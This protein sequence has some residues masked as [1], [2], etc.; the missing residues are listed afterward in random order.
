MSG[1]ALIARSRPGAW[2]GARP[3]C[4]GR[5][6]LAA[7]GTVLAGIVVLLAGCSGTSTGTPHSAAATPHAAASASARVAGV[8]HLVVPPGPVQ[9]GNVDDRAD[10]V[11]PFE[12][13]TGCQV[14]LKNASTDADAV[15]DIN[16]G[17][18]RSY[19]DG[20]L[21]SPE[22]LGQLAAV[23]ALQPL[24]TRRIGGYPV[25]SARLRGS[26]GEQ[27][28]GNVY[29]MPYSW[30]TY[31]TG[32]DSG[33]VKPAPQDWASLFA[34]AS[35]ARHAGKITVPDSP[36]TLALAALYLKSARPSLGI[37]DPFELTKPQLAA[38]AQAVS[39]ARPGVGTFWSQ[40]ATVIGQLGDGQDVL[41]AVL[42]HQIVE[43]SRAGLPAAGVP[44][45]TAAA[46]SGTVVGSVLS[47]MMTSQA[48]QTACMYRWLS[49]STSN[50]VQERVSAWTVSA[51]ASPA[52]CRG[53]AAANCTAFHMA[54][55]PTA[56]NI[57]FE[58][59]PV[60]DCG[61]ARTGCTGYAQ[62]RA[63]WQHIA[64]APAVNG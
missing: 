17:I 15:N 31:V 24:D 28:G 2:R 61:G 9:T 40:D 21:G 63:D 46:G 23:N 8:L 13:R 58:H 62:W 4:T 60:P 27:Y 11:T 6:R 39:A 30:D 16:H 47:W 12:K 34:P 20:V 64:G 56:R 52:A 1:N 5:R 14:E 35:A 42:N 37:T 3:G 41:G 44:A 32:F 25:L 48:P 53:P 10:W 36:V 26:P 33:Q 43:M 45:P 55:L 18:G 57:V 54:D 29:G 49:W 50:Y 22:V 38:A 51:P 7:A 59:L 19:Y